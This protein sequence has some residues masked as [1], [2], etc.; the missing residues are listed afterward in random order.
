MK[1]HG[2]VGQ[3]IANDTYTLIKEHY[4]IDAAVGFEE[5]DLRGIWSINF[6]KIDNLKK[7]E[8]YVEQK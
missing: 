3:E 6:G 8:D 2:T 7:S 4:P 5:G 1:C